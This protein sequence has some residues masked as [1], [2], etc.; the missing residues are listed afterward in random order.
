MRRTARAL[1]T[2]V[3]ASAALGVFAAPAPAQPGVPPPPAGT[4]RP[5]AEV[6]PA[7]VTPG[8]TVTVSVTCA[9][10]GGPAPATLDAASPAFDGGTVALRKV[11]AEAGTSSGPAYRGTARIAAAEDLTSEAQAATPQ[12]TWTVD[13]ACPE[14]SGE[15]Q[16]WSATMTAP[17]GPPTVPE[18][19]MTVPEEPMGVPDE[20][21]TAP[22]EG[23]GAVAPPCPAP[24]AP[25]GSAAGRGTPCAT[26]SACPEPAAP[27]GG[28]S[29]PWGN[30]GGTTA[31]HGVHAGAGGTFT[32]S[33]PAL[34]AGGVLIAAA[35]G[36]AAHRLLRSRPRGEAGHR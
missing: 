9:P 34:A 27:H 3:L 33:V 10:S 8:G 6:S 25:H 21:M 15:E 26:G 19:P 18:E 11:A 7:G 36:A 28:T 2:A 4:G 29:S 5:V 35:C 14:A 24:T 12:E 20:P 23:G 13:G 31:E 17:E 22:G 1:S 32:D 16:P 30:C